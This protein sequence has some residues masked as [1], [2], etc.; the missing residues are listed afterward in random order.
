M[1]DPILLSE[2][3]STEKAGKLFQSRRTTDAV[4][5][6]KFYHGDHL[7]DF[8]GWIGQLP[9]AT[10]PE[11]ADARNNVKKGFVSE[12]VIAEVVDRHRSGILGREPL[13]GFLPSDVPTP[14]SE[15]RRKLFSKAFKL[16]QTTIE[17]VLGGGRVKLAQEADDA[18][19]IWWNNRKPRNVLKEALDKALLEERAIVRFL[20]PAG[21]RN[22]QG[23]IPL[24]TSLSDAVNVPHLQVLTSDR[25]GIFV[26]ENTLQEFGLYVYQR[27]D[28]KRIA[29]LTF[30][31]NNVTF[32]RV[33]VDGEQP[34]DFTFD[35][36]GR[37]LMF[38]FRRAA[39][40]TPQVMSNQRALNLALT[41]MMRNVNLAGSLERTILNAEP[42]KQIKR[43]PDST[44]A[45]GYREEVIE[46][47]WLTGP[48]ATNALNGVFIKNESGEIIGRAN[49]NISYRDPVPVQTFTET[50][51]Q[52]YASILGQCQQRHALIS[53]DAVASGKSRSEARGEYRTSLADSKDPLDDAGRWLLET[54]LRLAAQFCGRTRDFLQLRADF[55]AIIEDGPVDPSDREQN[56][57]DVQA[58]LMSKE[59]AMSLNGIEDTDAELERISQEPQPTIDLTKPPLLE[60]RTTA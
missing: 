39:L 53:G 7:Q 57:S 49:P 23:Q 56:R 19:T 27:N 37:L 41:M 34:K 38:E 13:W 10:S 48:G 11:Y 59:T 54:E 25:A 31:E 18:L 44:D 45:R 51:D 22:E 28:N 52:F 35:L 14:A 6:D 43:I 16:V 12:N 21:L 36:G 20:F 29:E 9:P 60:Q 24:R 3:T 5:A 15:R 58:G 40:I 33:L 47:K 42:P 1:A 17:R 32:L 30:V 2:I 50:R 26:D 4:A 46:G 55:N 8:E